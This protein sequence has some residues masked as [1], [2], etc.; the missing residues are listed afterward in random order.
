M[1]RDHVDRYHYGSSD[2]RYRGFWGTGFRADRLP[3]TGEQTSGGTVNV[4]PHV[5]DGHPVQ[6]HTRGPPSP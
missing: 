6:G 3:S 4:R 5:R 2:N 1:P